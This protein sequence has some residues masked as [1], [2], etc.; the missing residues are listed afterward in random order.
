MSPT[1]HS[2]E[3]VQAMIRKFVDERDWN[4][5]HRPLALALSA[6]IEMGELLELFQW[7]TDSEILKALEDREYREALSFEIADVMIY[8]LRLADRTGINV[9]DA[10][11]QKMKKN[12][13]KYPVGKWNGK[14]PDKFSQSDSR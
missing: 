3:D 7:K 8:L 1:P 11:V 10:I 13:I 14:A 4:Q 12:E 5:Y 9:V 6:S 2:L